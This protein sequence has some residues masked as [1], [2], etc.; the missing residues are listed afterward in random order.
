MFLLSNG[1]VHFVT[2][3]QQNSSQSVICLYA[4]HIFQFDVYS[5]VIPTC[6]LTM[7]ECVCLC[8]YANRDDAMT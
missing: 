3:S 6:D 7:R 5:I 2:D 1:C 8:M 4:I